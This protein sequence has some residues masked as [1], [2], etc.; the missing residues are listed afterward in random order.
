MRVKTFRG[1][2]AKAVLA[3]IKK[4]LGGE[5]VILSNQTKREN[6]RSI[7]EIMAAVEEDTM[8]SSRQVSDEPALPAQSG[9]AGAQWQREWGEMKEHLNALLRPHMNLDTL[10]GR[11]KL[12][13][14]HLERE[15]VDQ[16]I[17]IGLYRELTCAQNVSILAELG[18]VARV[19]PYDAPWQE[20]LHLVAGPSGSGK[21]T[22][23]V[24]MALACKRAGKDRRICL[25]NCDGH[26]SKGRV[27]LKRY[28]DLAGI[29]SIE[30]DTPEE[31]TQVLLQCRNFDKIY[32]DLPSLPSGSTLTR[33]LTERHIDNRD[34]VA[35]HL[36][37]SPLYGPQQLRAFWERFQSPR[38]KSLIWTKLDEACSFGA[39]LNVAAMTGLPA[40]A[41]SYG[42]AVTGQMAAADSQALWKLIFTRQLPGAQVAQTVEMAA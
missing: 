3:Q 35:V 37:M 16:S 40:S 14:Q 36:V 21:T 41:L 28:A 42:P 10:T 38:V 7:C 1:E 39:I 9:P 34:D 22:A 11:Q 15:G 30:A 25:V 17:L 6:G 20:K 32:V 13:M 19:K 4:E 12:A 26:A 24:R 29:T 23:L 2:N 5:A 33:W 31:F 27:M 18:K 8:P